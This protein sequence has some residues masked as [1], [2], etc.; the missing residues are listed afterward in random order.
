M[1]PHTRRVVF[2]PTRHLFHLLQLLSRCGCV[3]CGEMIVLGLSSVLETN[4]KIMGAYLVV[5]RVR[6]VISKALVRLYS[7]VAHVFI[8]LVLPISALPRLVWLQ[9]RGLLL[10]SLALDDDLSEP[11]REVLQA[12]YTVSQELMLE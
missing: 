8:V 4:G 10:A 11:L 3:R 6:L 5:A 9:T 1:L 12:I 7:V 2:A